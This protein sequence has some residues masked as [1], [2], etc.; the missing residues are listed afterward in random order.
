LVLADVFHFDQL[1]LVGLVLN[2]A[3]GGLSI[4]L[5]TEITDR[6][7]FYIGDRKLD[8]TLF[9]QNSAFLGLPHQ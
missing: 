3:Q 2:L 7:K 8:K 9:L 4:L 6:S 5:K 1:Y